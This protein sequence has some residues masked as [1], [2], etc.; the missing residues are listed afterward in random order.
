V[1]VGQPDQAGGDRPAEAHHAQV[2]GHPQEQALGALGLGGL[3]HDPGVPREHQGLQLVNRARRRGGRD[4][5]Y[6]GFGSGLAG[7]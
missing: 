2:V 5:H 6:D 3:D 4:L 1:G 7:L